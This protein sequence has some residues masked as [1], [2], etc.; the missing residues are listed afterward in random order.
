MMAGSLA[1]HEAI[2]DY[3]FGDGGLFAAVATG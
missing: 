3:Y 1:H 2:Q